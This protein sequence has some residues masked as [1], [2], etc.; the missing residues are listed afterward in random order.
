MDRRIYTEAFLLHVRN[1]LDFLRPPP[2]QRKGSDVL[3]TD[4]ISDWKAP[5]KLQVGGRGA[6]DLRYQINKM[7]S[8]IT[9]TRK[10]IMANLEPDRWPID[11]IEKD[12]LELA[13]DFRRKLT[14]DDMRKWFDW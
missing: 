11:D 7:L 9:Y 10:A 5:P 8:H 4:Y 3:A 2:N 1:V 6:R 12:L 13:E 14:D